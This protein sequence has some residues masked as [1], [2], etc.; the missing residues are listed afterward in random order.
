ME[1]KTVFGKEIL[2]MKHKK[3]YRRLGLMVS[4]ALL[5]TIANLSIESDVLRTICIILPGISSII[6]ILKEM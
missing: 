4:I 5:I 3:L 2:V 6:L 1:L